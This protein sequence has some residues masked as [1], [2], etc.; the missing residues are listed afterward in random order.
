MNTD[1]PRRTR[2]HKPAPLRP[3]QGIA[4]ISPAGPSDPERVH[5]GA[6]RLARLGYSVTVS[7]H[8]LGRY[9]YFSGLDRERLDDL[10]TAFT[11]P[12]IRA[13][14]CARGGYGSGRLLQ[15]LPYEAIARNPKIFVGF[16][17][18]TA[19]NWALYARSR[20]V[21]F[22]GPLVNEIGDGLPDLTLRSFFDMVDP[23]AV[24]KN[25]WPHPL[26]ALRPGEARGRLF[27]GCLS[28]M[29]TLLGTPFLPDLRG[30]I[31]ILED[32]D[33]KPYHVDRMLTHL[34]NAGV[35]DQLAGLVVGRMVKCWP[36]AR[37]N[38]DLSLEEILLDLT[39]AH[40]LPIYTGLPYGHH[41]ERLTL[42]VGA[43]ARVSPEGVELLEDPLNRRAPRF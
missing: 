13:V 3:G 29:V 33:E 35:L 12:R 31:L 28:L 9:A 27:P 10:T 26:T 37:R 20:L 6:D 17:D 14:L 39:S 2:H 1:S 25:L 30:A 22:T 42:P 4:V 18:L 19:L 24:Q 43:R 38:D 36:K 8:A 23:S 34:K 15:S 40:P 21:T 5:R 41:P 16:S 11:D 7:P 32:T